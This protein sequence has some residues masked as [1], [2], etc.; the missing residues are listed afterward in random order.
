MTI[1]GLTGGIGA[2]KSV[3]ARMFEEFGIPVIDADRTG[4]TILEPGGAAV[5]GVVDAFGEDVLSGGVI[6]RA[7]L[8]RRVFGDPEALE[9][10]NGLTHPAVGIEIVRRAAE[11]AVAGHD[12]VLIEAA[13]H[14]E[15]GELGP[16]IEA[17]VLVT[18]PREIRV[19][20][21]V[22]SRG[23]TAD[24]ANARIDAQTPPEAKMP[25]APWIIDNAGS[26]GGLRRRVAEVA[27]EIQ[28]WK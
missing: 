12:T 9:R 17:L 22:E 2:G 25:L 1:L 8:A 21:L 13:L 5:K 14:A 16:G 28:A 7:K 19:R 11:L 10:L 23:M 4:H 3:A 27:R 18:C 20:R 6:D 26:T 15:N 24:E